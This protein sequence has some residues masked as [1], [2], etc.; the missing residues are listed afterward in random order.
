MIEQVKLHISIKQA[1]TDDAQAIYLLVT[2]TVAVYI[3]RG[4][5]GHAWLHDRAE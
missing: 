5:T 2:C 4:E 3:M 1:V